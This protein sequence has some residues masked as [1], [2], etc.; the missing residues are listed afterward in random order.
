MKVDGGEIT[1]DV[2]SYQLKMNDEKT[3]V[4]VDWEQLLSIFFIWYK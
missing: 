2:Q 1:N 3:V 4:N